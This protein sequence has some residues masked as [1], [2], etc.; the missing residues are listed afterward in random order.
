MTNRTFTECLIHE[1]KKAYVKYLK[2]L[3]VVGI[4]ALVVYVG[5]ILKLPEWAI[6][7]VTLLF[8]TFA[9]IAKN[10]VN[11]LTLVPW[12]G[13]IAVLI[14]V[15]PA[16]YATLKCIWIRA[17]LDAIVIVGACTVFTGGVMFGVGIVLTNGFI[18]TTGLLVFAL[19]FLGTILSMAIHEGVF[20]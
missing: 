17:S 13:Y 9:Y 5:Q 8:A 4:L 14:I 1:S 11:A 16:I 7:I 18:A 6:A 12:W 15:I 20:K 19:S 2:I 10:I 3:G